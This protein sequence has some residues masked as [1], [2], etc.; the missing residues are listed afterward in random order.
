VPTWVL[1]GAVIYFGISTQATAA[2]AERA[3]ELLM[4]GQL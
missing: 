2:V 3:A 1:I 4:M